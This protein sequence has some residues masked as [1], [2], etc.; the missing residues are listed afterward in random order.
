[1]SDDVKQTDTI[2]DANV[3][4][5]VARAGEPAVPD[6]AFAARVT[7][8]RCSPPASRAPP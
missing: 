1:M 5:L 2:G 7:E 3:A 4:A 8:R 6:P